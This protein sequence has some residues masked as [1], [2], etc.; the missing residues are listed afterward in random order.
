MTLSASLSSTISGLVSGRCYPNRRP[1]DKPVPVI[2]FSILTDLPEN[3]ICGTGTL[4]NARV[5]LDVWAATYTAAETLA[6]Q[7]I[8][9]MA[10]SAMQNVLIDSHPE[11]DDT[12]DLHRWVLD[13]S[14]WHN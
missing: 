6:G 14:I 7:V 13:Y 2:V 9:A 12:E 5:Q 4:Y 1:Q 3:T 11:P 10:A 8:A